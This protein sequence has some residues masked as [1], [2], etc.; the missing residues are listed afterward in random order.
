MKV[1]WKKHSLKFRFEAGT[2]RG[3]LKRKISYFIIIQD[4][5]GNTGIGECSLLPGLSM[6]NHPYYEKR[7]DAVCDKVQNSKI[8]NLDTLYFLL[9]ESIGKSWPSISMGLETAFLDYFQNGDKV[10]YRND[11]LKGEGIPINGLI[12]MGD[13]D[14]MLQQVKQKIKDGYV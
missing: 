12:W 4:E 9:E 1:S 10:I 8:S 6:D 11:F 14:F 13:K 5:A 3:I 7:L 2:S